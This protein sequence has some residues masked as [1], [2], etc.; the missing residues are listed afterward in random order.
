MSSSSLS[1][2]TNDTNNE[3]V[4]ETPEQLKASFGKLLCFANEEECTTV[5]I[6]PLEQAAILSRV[7]K[8][9]VEFPHDNKKTYIAKFLKST[10][11]LEE[12]FVV[13]GTFYRQY[14]QELA[15][16]IDG[17]FI[18]QALY[19]GKKCLVLEYIENT[20]SYTLLESCPNHQIAQVWTCLAGIHGH[21][22]NTPIV[23][24]LSLTAGIG[25][26]M[27]G[28]E[29]ER[30][31]PILWSDFCDSL[32]DLSDEQRQRLEEVCE[33]LSQ[34]RLREIHEQVHQHQYTCIHGDF[35]VGN[36]L[37]HEDTL[38]VLDWATCGR[39]NHMIDVVFFFLVSTRLSIQEVFDKWLPFYY[40]SL[41]LQCN[42][43][44]AFEYSW[45]TCVEDFKTCLLNQFIILVCYDEISKSLLKNQVDSK[46][47]LQHYS[48]H[49]QNVNKRCVEA[50]L[51]KEMN[52]EQYPLPPLK[53]TNNDGDVEACNDDMVI[54]KL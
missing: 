26:A 34:R 41:I 15:R 25:T 4:I 18:P 43:D 1:I 36:L 7:Y 24:G 3:L 44:N 13:E 6:V 14:A 22:W 40:N 9:H 47:E 31:F 48:Q 33:D 46:E 32:E 42:D 29:K 23:E 17:I 37:F 49:F 8:V 19:C 21:F 52:L 11:P 16:P 35:H 12:M 51:S 38:V 53:T 28:Q 45:E 10:L 30:T 27:T 2:T 20:T 5:E 54:R 39:G 50:L